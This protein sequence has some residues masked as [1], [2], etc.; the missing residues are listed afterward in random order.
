MSSNRSRS[1]GH[2]DRHDVQPVEQVLP[3]PSLGDLGFEI[4]VGGGEHPHVHLDR[5][6]AA[7]AGDDAFLEHPQQL[8]LRG[9]RHVAD[10]VE[11]ERAAVGLLELAGAVGEGAR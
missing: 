1:G 8:G 11:E 9:K 5:L 7:D 4:L 2:L 6:R 10:F 3:E